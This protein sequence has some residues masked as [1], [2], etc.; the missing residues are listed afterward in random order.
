MIPSSLSS[1]TRNYNTRC[2]Y[3][4]DLRSN[5]R[6][7]SLGD[8]APPSNEPT[9]GSRNIVILDERAGIFPVTE[10]DSGKNVRI[11]TGFFGVKYCHL[12]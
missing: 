8:Y 11:L 7:G 1:I 5:E 6:E 4:D 3:G 9:G 10:T 12:S 2:T